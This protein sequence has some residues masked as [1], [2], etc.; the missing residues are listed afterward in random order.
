M[1][2]VSRRR[3]RRYPPAHSPLTFTALVQ[4]TGAALGGA[5]PRTTL[6]AHLQREFDADHVLLTDSGTDA[7]QLALRVARDVVGP[8][9]PIALPAYS[10]YDVATAAA[11][12]G[13]TLALY[14]IDPATLGPDLAS[15]RRC[16]DDGARAVVIATLYGVPPD[17]GALR[18]ELGDRQILVVEDAAQ[19]HGASWDG[20]SLGRHAPISVLSFGRGKGWTGASGG[21]VLFRAPGPWDGDLTTVGP[22]SILSELVGLGKAASQWLLGRPSLYSYCAMIPGLHLGETRYHAPR[23]VRP[24]RRGAAML[25]ERTRRLALVEAIARRTAGDRFAHDIPRTSGIDR[26]TPPERARAGWLRYPLLLADGLAGFADRRA[27]TAL[28]VARGYPQPLA[29]LPAVVERLAPPFRG[30]VWPG[31]ET[32]ADRLVTLPTHG[33]LG[34]KDREALL[35]LVRGYAATVETRSRSYTAR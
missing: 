26:V 8:G 2:P 27:A 9:A 32:L 21:A 25:L 16:V 5:D 11:G 29:Q 34:T 12:A 30:R 10:C 24:M 7:L 15:L 4:A 28:G 14:D 18:R 31:A 3:R 23:N 33:L 19:G 13:A 20:R 17:W 22:R 35:D 6:A 1:D